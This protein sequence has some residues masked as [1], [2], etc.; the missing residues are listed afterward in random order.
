MRFLSSN[1][2]V[3]RL[4]ARLLDI[5]NPMPTRIRGKLPRTLKEKGWPRLA[6]CWP[7]AINLPHRLNP[8]PGRSVGSCGAGTDPVG[9]R[10]CARP[11]SPVHKAEQ[12]SC[13]L[14][15]SRVTARTQPKGFHGVHGQVRIYFGKQ[16]TSRTHIARICS[17]RLH[18]ICRWAARRQNRQQRTTHD[19]VLEKRTTEAP[20]SL[21][22]A[23]PQCGNRC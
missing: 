18:E 12:L 20:L 15:R 5:A 23:S 8:F 22:L 1:R 13:N 17:A 3:A 6:P 21:V 16:V 4:P 10:A 14:T 2:A 7:L 9:S 11:H 19:A